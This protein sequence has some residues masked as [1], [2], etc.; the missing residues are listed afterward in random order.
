MCEIVY[1]VKIISH[2]S[3][4][5]ATYH[6]S[7][8]LAFSSLSGSE[9]NDDP[10][11][12]H[13]ERRK[14]LIHIPYPMSCKGIWECFAHD[15]ATAVNISIYFLSRLRLVHATC[16]AFTTKFHRC[17]IFLTIDGDR[18]KIKKARFARVAFLL[19]HDAYANELG[20][21]AEHVNEACV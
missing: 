10:L 18:I 17:L 2:K 1:P 14:R 15:I 6:S 20:L 21:I 7:K 8:T 19:H 13:Y 11:R 3:V 9:G 4:H 5:C 16:Y 12:M